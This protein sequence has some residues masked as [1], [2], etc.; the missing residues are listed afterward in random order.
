MGGGDSRRVAIFVSEFLSQAWPHTSAKGSDP[1]DT[2]HPDNHRSNT[3][4]RTA[5]AV[6]VNT[7]FANCVGY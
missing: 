7:P 2:T 3:N 4:G 1:I 5:Q 6:I